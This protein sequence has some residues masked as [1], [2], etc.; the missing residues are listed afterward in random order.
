LQFFACSFQDDKGDALLTA[1]EIFSTNKL[2]TISI[3]LLCVN[4]SIN[5]FLYLFFSP[6]FKRTFSHLLCCC[7]RVCCRHERCC[8]DESGAL[9]D[10]CTTSSTGKNED[11]DDDHDH[12]DH[13]GWKSL[14]F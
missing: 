9:R 14:H 8:C 7:C 6:S 3:F 1:I 12:D 4:S 11:E 10:L 2:C 13:C 5:V